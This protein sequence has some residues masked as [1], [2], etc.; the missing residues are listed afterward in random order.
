MVSQQSYLARNI[1]IV[2]PALQVISS[3]KKRLIEVTKKAGI[4]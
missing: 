4:K 2:K 3:D 1:I